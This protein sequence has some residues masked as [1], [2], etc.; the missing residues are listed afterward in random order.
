MLSFGV[1]YSEDDFLKL[2][3]VIYLT[4]ESLNMI[5]SG[6]PFFTNPTKL[7]MIVKPKQYSFFEEG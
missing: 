7:P 1:E 4:K 5:K 6:L 2:N 3:K